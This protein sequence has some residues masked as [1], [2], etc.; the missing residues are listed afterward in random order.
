MVQEL[1]LLSSQ[2]GFKTIFSNASYEPISVSHSHSLLYFLSLSLSLSPVCTHTHTRMWYTQSTS[3]HPREVLESQA[4]LPYR[5]CSQSIVDKPPPNSGVLFLTPVPSTP[6]LPPEPSGFVLPEPASLPQRITCPDSDTHCGLHV[7][8][9]ESP[10]P[11][12]VRLL[13][14]NTGPAPVLHLWF[15]RLGDRDLIYVI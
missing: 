3:K 13:C 9:L 4:H 12:L 5:I 14:L 8:F 15:R 11:C 7:S 2:L 1:F 6:A 10:L